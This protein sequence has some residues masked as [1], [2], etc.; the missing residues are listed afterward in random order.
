M[1][2][3]LS[4]KHRA[5]LAAGMAAPQDNAAKPEG[6]KGKKN[7][8]VCEKCK[9]HVVSVDVDQGVTPFTI[10][11]KATAFCSGWM[12]SSMYR[13]WDQDMRADWEWYRPPV[14]QILSPQAQAHVDQ[15]GLLLRK[16]TR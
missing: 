7:I 6:F 9:G 2:E 4:P 1:S 14:V 3:K 12:K 11:C 8:Y 13:V 16:A 5:Q 10:D 15:G